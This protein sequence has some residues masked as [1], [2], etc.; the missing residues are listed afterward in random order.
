MHDVDFVQQLD[1]R[2]ASSGLL[3]CNAEMLQSS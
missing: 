2:V 3:A 1:V